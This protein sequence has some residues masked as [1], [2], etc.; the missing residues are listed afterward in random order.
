MADTIWSEVYSWI[1]SRMDDRI[2][3]DGAYGAQC[4]D[5][6]SA[7]GRQ[8]H[9][10]PYWR[11]HG[12]AKAA[13]AVTALGWK[14]IEPGQRAQAGDVASWGPSWGGGYGHTAVVLSDYGNY[15]RCFSQ[16]PGPARLMTLSKRDLLG[17]ARPTRYVDGT[18]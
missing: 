9:G 17:Y 5:L 1:K 2:D 12:K 8:V 4:V 16:N 10:T 13:N 15:L 7:Y 18:P 11:G 14:W 3:E 6:V